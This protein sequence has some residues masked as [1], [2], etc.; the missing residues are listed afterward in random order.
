MSGERVE[1][2]IETI[3]GEEG[4]AERRPTARAGGG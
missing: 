4:Q 3:A 2:G 1:R